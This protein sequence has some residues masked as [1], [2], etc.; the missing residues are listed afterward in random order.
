MLPDDPTLSHVPP[1]VR[2]RAAAIVAHGGR[3]LLHQVEGDGFW[4]LPGG[5]IEPGESA[6]EALARELREELGDRLGAG[7]AVGALAVVAENFFTYAGSAYHEIG[8][9]LHASP[10]PGGALVLADGPY[11]GV[12]GTRK[13]VFAWFARAELARLEIRPA[14]LQAFLADRLAEE[15]TGVLHIVHRDPPAPKD[16]GA[17]P[18]A[19]PTPG[20]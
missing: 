4:A 17:A 1:K 7:I 6:S 3:V 2:Q 11:P 19:H 13:L 18:Q 8:L 12:E 9:Y 14:F 5:A 15:P 16:T 10:V 20:R